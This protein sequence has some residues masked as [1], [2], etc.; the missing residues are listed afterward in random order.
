MNATPVP[1]APASRR[2]ASRAIGSARLVAAAPAS[3]RQLLRWLAVH[4]LVRLASRRWAASGDPQAMLIADPASRLDPRPVYRR[5]RAA[6][7]LCR[8]RVSLITVDHAICQQVLRAEEFR[9]TSLAGNV[10]PPMQWL[11]RRTRQLSLHPLQAPSLLVVEPPEHTRYRTL[12]S[13]VF[14]ARAVA[15]LRERVQ[16]TADR[17]LDEL[18][19]PAERGATVELVSRYCAQLPVS[20]IGDILGVPV[21]QRSTVLHFGELA[22]P[23]LDIGLPLGQFRTVERGLA[24]FDRWLTG[25][26]DRLRRQPGTDLLSQLIQA[27]SDGQALD[28][29]E[30]RATAGLL[31][32][33]GF[34]T[35]VNLLSNGVHLLA[36]QPDQL[37]VLRAEPGHWPNAVDEILRLE[38]PV[39]LT[40]RVA[41]QAIM[42]ADQQVQQ[43]ETVV[44]VLAGANRDPAVFAD[45]DRFDVTRANAA[46]HLSFSGG[47]HF[48]LGA[49]LARAE[50]EIGLRSLFQ[51][52][53][54]LALAGAPVSRPTRVLRGWQQLPVRL[55]DPAA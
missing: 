14:T 53:P 5:I 2:A 19:E 34:E 20:V 4:G 41:R 1:P 45:P 46:R 47:R 17:L 10:P 39:Q 44:L 33:A 25:H 42:L 36:R 6:G 16:L 8:T 15:G 22:A 54:G 21:D 3:G 35:T 48:C 18:A 31:L 38:S 43:G 7:P 51:R 52:Y 30:L 13:S 37:A 55:A 28:E 9:T 24:G 40:A 49:A 50:G 27:R 12:V 23:S 26:I 32:A 11:E 29:L